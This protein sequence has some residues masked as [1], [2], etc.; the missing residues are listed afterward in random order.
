MAVWRVWTRSVPARVLLP[1]V[2]RGWVVGIPMSQVP[3]DRERAPEDSED[4]P[5]RRAVLHP[6]PETGG[7]AHLWREELALGWTRRHRKEL[8]AA[9]RRLHAVPDDPRL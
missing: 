9:A 8:G 7:D 1:E 2:R 6:V 4:R 3:D 5:E